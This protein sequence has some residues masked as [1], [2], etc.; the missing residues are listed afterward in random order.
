MNFFQTPT[1]TRFAASWMAIC[2]LFESLFVL[3]LPPSRPIRQ[4]SCP[5]DI[6]QFPSLIHIYISFYPRNLRPSQ[7]H[8]HPFVS[9]IAMVQEHTNK[10]LPIP[11]P[12]QRSSGRR[13]PGHGDASTSQNR[14]IS[15][16]SLR[17]VSPPQS[18]RLVTQVAYLT[19]PPALL[20]K[21]HQTQTP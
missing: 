19:R 3:R 11:P 10:P 13:S 1:V 2:L 9:Y 6:F 7:H 16:Q 14:A 17:L 20:K 15:S 12:G 8:I 18:S 4:T 21:S 5:P